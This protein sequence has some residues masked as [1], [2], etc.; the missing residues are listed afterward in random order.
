[1][2]LGADEAEGFVEAAIWIGKARNV[3]E[4]MRSEEF[5]G[6][7]FAGEMDK[8]EVR[9][10]RLYIGADFF[11][12][13]DGFPAEGATEMAEENEKDWLRLRE[14][15]DV[16]AGLREIRVNEFRDKTRGRGHGLF[17]FADLS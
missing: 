6:S 7:V 15:G 16:F 3:F 8:G 10:E 12:F 1:M 17:I 2:P 11:D 4:M 5:L 9:A 14:G 13:A